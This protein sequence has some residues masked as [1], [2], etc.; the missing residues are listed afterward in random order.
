MTEARRTLEV[1]DEDI[2]GLTLVLLGGPR[3]AHCELKNICLRKE[4]SR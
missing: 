3:V 4:Q 1:P 2:Q